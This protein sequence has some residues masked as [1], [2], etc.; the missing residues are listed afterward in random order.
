MAHNWS[1]LEASLADFARPM[2]AMGL[3]PLNHLAAIPSRQHWLVRC[4]GAEHTPAPNLTVLAARGPFVL[5]N[6]LALMRTYRVD[7]LVSK[8]SGGSAVA[9]KLQ[10]A[11]RLGIPVAMLRRPPLSPADR[12]FG[13]VD[14]LA[15]ELLA[16][17]G[18][19]M[20]PTPE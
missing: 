16:A 18:A 7:V 19:S 10:A 14:V 6:E 15:A 17:R 20:P 4:L 12:E 13:D 5:E 8:N 2:F 11:R 3:E 9:A 1:D